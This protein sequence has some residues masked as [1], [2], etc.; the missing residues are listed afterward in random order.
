MEQ[1]DTLFNTASG[2]FLVTLFVCSDGL[3]GIFLVEID[4]A[5]GIIYLVEI[6]FVVIR[7]CHS[8]QLADHLV[9]IVFR[10]D[11]CH[12]NTGIEGKFVRRIQANHVL[13]GFIGFLL[14]ADGCLQLS[15]Q[16]PF[17]CLLLAAHFMADYFFEV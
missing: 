3:Q 17:A 9:G 14:V 7:S 4:V 12:G 1:Q 8:L 5:D 16:I 13:E 10:H 11:F 2:G 15:H 6:L